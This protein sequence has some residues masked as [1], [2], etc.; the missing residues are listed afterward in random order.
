MSRSERILPKFVRRSLSLS[1]AA[2]L[3][4]PPAPDGGAVDFD[5]D[6]HAPADL[7]VNDN[8]AM[9]QPD[10]D[11]APDALQGGAH[12]HVADADRDAQQQEEDAQ[13]DA[14]A[15]IDDD[16]VLFAD[17][18]ECGEIDQGNME[19]DAFNDDAQGD[20]GG[21]ANDNVDVDADAD[22]PDA[23]APDADAGAAPAPNAD[24]LDA[25][26][27]ARDAAPAP[28]LLASTAGAHGWFRLAYIQ[29]HLDMISG[30]GQDAA[31]WL[32]DNFA[33]LRSL[34]TWSPFEFL[35]AL[36]MLIGVAILITMSRF[37]LPYRAADFL[38]S[39]LQKLLC[40]FFLVLPTT[41]R[42]FCAETN[43]A[44]IFA[45]ASERG[46]IR[47]R[48]VRVSFVFSRLVLPLAACA[49]SLSRACASLSRSVSFFLPFSHSLSLSLSHAHSLRQ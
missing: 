34:T 25:D 40:V 41:V 28:A 9:H 12:D 31:R 46:L 11:D 26:A 23:D 17:D 4:E 30:T 33:W 29:P 15:L 49:L 24:A 5:V 39:I 22:A 47:V 3:H 38:F 14:D 19:A 43:L 37:N 2:S 10:S 27:G 1:S 48:C 8:D 7:H 45:D 21:D 16:D 44:S 13:A 36:A 32:H 6:V 20:D 35:R 42:Q 18:D